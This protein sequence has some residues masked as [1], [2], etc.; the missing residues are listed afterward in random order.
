MT[1]AP[2]ETAADPVSPTDR[3]LAPL[4]VTDRALLA[5]VR[6][7]ARL[8]DGIAAGT[9]ALGERRA[10]AVGDWV[11]HVCEAIRHRHDGEEAVLWPVLTQH[12]GRTLDLSGLRDDHVALRGLLGEVRRA[13]RGLVG[14]VAVRP[15]AVA[16][17]EDFARIR[18]LARLLGELAD[19]LDEHRRD[20]ERELGAVLRGMPRADWLRAAGALHAGAPDPAFTAA[21]AH[22]TASS[23]DL[24]AVHAALGGRGLAGVL[25]RR[26]L[27]RRE[28]LVFGD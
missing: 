2:P 22:A 1:I 9:V 6:R 5:D 17:A 12:A 11:E 20:A 8:A 24:A 7:L 28:R 23:D 15:I 21:R 25:A 16:S 26:S 10:L 19:L 27:R 14:A 3:D 13:T 18:R 4:R